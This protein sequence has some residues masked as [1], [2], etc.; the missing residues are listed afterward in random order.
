MLW[1]HILGYILVVTPLFMV[2][3][4]VV[5]TIRTKD[6]SGL[7]LSSQLSWTSSWLMWSLYGWYVGSMP[8]FL[9]SLLGLIIDL[10]LLVFIVVYTLREHS[11]RSALHREGSHILVLLTIFPVVIMYLAFG[12]EP[13]ILNLAVADFVALLPQLL[14]TFR[15][16]SLSGLS[17]SSWIV[18]TVVATGWIVYGFGI[19]EVLSVAWAFFM[20]PVYVLVVVRIV[21]DRRKHKDVCEVSDEIHD[22]EL[23]GHS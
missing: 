3:P 8:V 12:V 23:H 10:V 9:N 15:S 1:V 11:F 7:S 13:A 16:S 2:G 22:V 21:Y 19:S 17:L 18:K 14:N 4:Q 20:I 6:V 5:R